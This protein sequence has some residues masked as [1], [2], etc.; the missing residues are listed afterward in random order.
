MPYEV[1]WLINTRVISC[2]FF[3]DI[4]EADGID[5]LKEM[6]RMIDA[7]T[8]PVFVV[9]DALEITRVP[10]SLIPLVQAITELQLDK[11]KLRYLLVLSNNPLHSFIG[12]IAAK[13]AGIHLRLLTDMNSAI[14]FIRTHDAELNTEI[15]K[16]VGQ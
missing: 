7:G 11:A 2:R 6:A 16:I 3:G 1:G 4:V 10:K 8:A 9:I 15:S 13:F 12:T 14:D 5:L